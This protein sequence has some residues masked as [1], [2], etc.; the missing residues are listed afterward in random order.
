ME[1]VAAILVI[2]VALGLIGLS[3]FGPKGQPDPVSATFDK[4]A[5]INLIQG[6][7][8]DPDRLQMSAG[9]V[10]ITLRNTSSILHQFEIYDPVEDRVIESWSS[11]KANNGEE[12]KWVELVRGR[13]YEM[14]EPTWRS[15]GMEGV[16]IAR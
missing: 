4:E 12:S 15:K 16:L 8:M 10:K 6:H 1:K 9:R 2:L 11:I 13:R 7:R 3:V 14:Y 5:T